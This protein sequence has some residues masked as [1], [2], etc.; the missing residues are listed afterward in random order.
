MYTEKDL[1]KLC[2]KVIHANCPTSVITYFCNQMSSPREFRDS[3]GRSFLHHAAMNG[4]WG[5]AEILL[6]MNFDP[7]AIEESGMTPLHLLGRCDD[8]M[9]IDA[10]LLRNAPILA[11]DF[12]G[13]TPFDKL[14]SSCNYK[15]AYHLLTRFADRMD[16]SSEPYVEAEG[17]IPGAR[18]VDDAHAERLQDRYRL[19]RRKYEIFTNLGPRD[20]QRFCWWS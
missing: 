2:I 18:P 3:L 19:L 9:F 6:S 11:E 14:M 8:P 5:I 1:G 10:L 4:S 13:K 16:N 12:F 20:Q 7:K 15:L 17:I